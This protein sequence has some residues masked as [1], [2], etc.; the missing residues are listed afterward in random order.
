MISAQITQALLAICPKNSIWQTPIDGLF[1]HH[2][3]SPQMMNGFRQQPSL[4]MMLMG[5]R[6]LCI[7]N[8]CCRFNQDNMS[9]CPVNTPVTMTVDHATPNKPYFALSLQFDLVMVARI[10]SQLN[11]HNPINNSI[12]PQDFLTLF[13][14]NQELINALERLLTLLYA[15][16]FEQKITILAPLY[17]QEIYYYL[18]TSPQGDKLCELCRQGSH[19]ERI[20]KATAWLN[21]HFSEPLDIAQLASLCGMSI[22]GFYQHFRHITQQSP[23][24]YQKNLRLTEAQHQIQQHSAPISQIAYNVGYESP[25]QFSREYKRYFGRAPSEEI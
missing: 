21:Q 9:L 17:L 3:D 8:E 13:N 19:A 11:L 1:L 14:P 6:Q 2:L 25:S 12:Q 24:Q 20:S 23:L 15:P 10:A 5:E 7:G 18:L 4:C 22:S 16:N